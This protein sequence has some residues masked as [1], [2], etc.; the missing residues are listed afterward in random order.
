MKR[1]GRTVS[2][3]AIRHRRARKPMDITLHLGAHRTAST[4]FQNYLRENRKDLRRHRI[5][6]WGPDRTRGGLLRGV[7]PI[8]GTQ[9]TPNDQFCRARGRVM[10]N[11]RR[12]ESI[13]LRHLVVSDE[14]M[15]GAP[16]RNLRDHSLYAGAGERVAR[17]GGAFDGQ[18]N[19]VY[20]SIRSQESYWSSVIAYAVS[21]GHK[22]PHVDDLDRLVTNNRCWRD[23]IVDLACALP[24]AE[25]IVLPYELYGGLPERKLSLMTGLDTPPMAHAR[26][27]MNRAPSL[28]QLR[29]ALRDRGS[30]PALLPTGEGRWVPFD[31]AQTMAL[32][33]S[34]ADDLFWLRA[35][36]DGLATL[37]EETRPG[38]MGLTPQQVMTTRGQPD[39]IEERRMA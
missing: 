11:L 13:G 32:R 21:R 3:N 18:I 39:G 4:V 20:L 12:L 17:Y 19:R 28:P 16:R 35:G 27:W 25:I 7:I 31:P 22:I 2:P 9:E 14:N 26:E 1:M 6:V 10:L 24:S 8:P 37:T 33:E 29:Q 30:D 5:S 34:Y 36:A 15:L 23:V 38:K